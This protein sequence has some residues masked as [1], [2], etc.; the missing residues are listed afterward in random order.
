M[1]CHRWR[2]VSGNHHP[3]TGPCGYRDYPCT[4]SLYQV[5]A[6]VVLDMHQVEDYRYPCQVWCHTSVLQGRSYQQSY[7]NTQPVLVLAWWD[8]QEVVVD[9][10]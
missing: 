1:V 8:S 5:L 4:N 9:T 3:Y 7:R 2:V 6:V 10:E